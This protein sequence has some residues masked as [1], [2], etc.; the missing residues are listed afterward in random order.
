MNLGRRFAV[1]VVSGLFCALAPSPAIRGEEPPAWKVVKQLP[2]PEAV[3]AAAADER[4]FYAIASALVAKYDRQ[5]GQ[6]VAESTGKA[7]HLNSGFFYQ[8][9][10]L[11]AHSNYPHTP[12]KSE[13]KA[14]DPPT[15]RLETFHDFGSYG[16]SL[17]WAVRRGG[18]WWA[19]FARY[20]DD[21]AKT[22]LVKFDDHWREQ[23]R[24]TYP[25]EVIQR[26]G[27]YSLS[28]GLWWGDLLLATDHDHGRLYALRL[29]ESGSTLKFAG[30]QTAPFTG[31]GIAYDPVTHGLIGINRAQRLLILAAPP[32]SGE[33]AK[34]SK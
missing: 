26:I 12:E 23:A 1:A 15:M 32:K 9:K 34:G 6:R 22:F 10:L 28:G 19:N 27:K 17:T 5:T 14:L 21:N 4:Y 3:Q 13:L 30:T 11:C 18:H 7:E 2:A 29:P 16:G 25:P 24:W 31:Q 33:A 8:G 20:G